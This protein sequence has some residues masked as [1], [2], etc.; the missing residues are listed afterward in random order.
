MAARLGFGAIGFGVERLGF[1]ARLTSECPVCHRSGQ[2]V[3]EHA[4][5]VKGVGFRV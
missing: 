1:G 2:K 5:R 4:L 3:S